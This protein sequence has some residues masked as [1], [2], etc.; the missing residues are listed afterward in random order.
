M[1]LTQ[2]LDPCQELSSEYKKLL[3]FFYPMHDNFPSYYLFKANFVSVGNAALSKRPKMRMF[4]KV[5]LHCLS[6]MMHCLSQ[7]TTL[8]SCSSSEF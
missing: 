4:L 2:T 6:Q 8:Q 5:A 7:M 1:A 3:H